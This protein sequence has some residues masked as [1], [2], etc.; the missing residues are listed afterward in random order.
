ME[1]EQGSLSAVNKN[2]SVSIT[3]LTPSTLSFLPSASP[4]SIPPLR[5]LPGVDPSVYLHHPAP[6][7]PSNRAW[8][9]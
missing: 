2:A 7:F 8:I 5:S 6:M 4:D 1:G 9:I 3:R